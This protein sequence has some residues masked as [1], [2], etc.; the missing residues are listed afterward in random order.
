MTIAASVSVGARRE[1]WP[2]VRW[3]M[4]HGDIVAG[5]LRVP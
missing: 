1:L 3:L 5:T 2:Y 4:V